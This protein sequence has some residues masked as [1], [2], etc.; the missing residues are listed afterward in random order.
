[1]QLKEWTGH[2]NLSSL[3]VYI[4]LAF[5]DLAGTRKTY[6]AVTLKAAV[7][8]TRDRLDLLKSNAK[9]K[10]STTTEVFNEFERLLTAFEADIVRSLSQNDE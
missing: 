7:E 6:N 10:K 4:D 5:A 9:A 3:D 1:M 2:T 8:V